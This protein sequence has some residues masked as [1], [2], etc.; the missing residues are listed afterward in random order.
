MEK[1]RQETALVT[2][3]SRGIGRAVALELARCGYHVVVNYRSSEAEAEKTVSLIEAEGGSA[4]KLRFDVA[5]AAE[6]RRSVEDLIARRPSLDVLVNNAGITADNL[7]LMMSEEDWNTVVSTTL[8]GFYNVTQPVIKSMMRAHRGSVVSMSSLSALVGNRGQVNYSAAKAGLIAA[9]RSLASEV[10]RLGIR[11]N[12]IAPGLIRTEMT[13][14]LPQ[15]QIRER[16]PMRRVG[17][18]EEVAKVV[19][20]LCSPDASYITGQV[21]SVNGG[22]F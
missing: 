2:G 18:P 20:F 6:S 16:I 4:E 9:S 1:N 21:I 15:E 10:A 5:D 13:S 8:N 11:V 17:E 22:M 7:F 3:A 12:V 14:N 19:R